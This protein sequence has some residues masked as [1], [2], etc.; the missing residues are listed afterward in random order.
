MWCEPGSGGGCGLGWPLLQN[1]CEH[2]DLL[3]SLFKLFNQCIVHRQCLLR[4]PKY[5][6]YHWF[7]V[8]IIFF[9]T[10]SKSCLPSST[11]WICH[12]DS[13]VLLVAPGNIDKRVLCTDIVLDAWSIDSSRCNKRM[14]AI[15]HNK[16]IK[17]EI[18]YNQTRILNHSLLCLHHH[19][20]HLLQVRQRSD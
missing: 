5:C 1:I 16:S 3:L 11:T 18:K 14:A 4:A 10:K 12:V 8:R 15:N 2:L 7:F 13:S 6:L 17:N 20:A 19:P 9:F